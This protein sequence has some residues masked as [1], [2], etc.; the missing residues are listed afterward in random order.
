MPKKDNKAWVAEGTVCSVAKGGGKPAIDGSGFKQFKVGD[1]I[2]VVKAQPS[3][4]SKGAYNYVCSTPGSES[5]YRF[6]FNEMNVGPKRKKRVAG[7][8][9]EAAADEYSREWMR[10]VE[11]WWNSL[12]EGPSITAKENFVKSLAAKKTSIYRVAKAV[13]EILIKSIRGISGPWTLDEKACKVDVEPFSSDEFVGEASWYV[14]PAA[15]TCAYD[16]TLNAG[17]VSVKY[18]FSMLEHEFV[19]IEQGLKRIKNNGP[20]AGVWSKFNAKGW[21]NVFKVPALSMTSYKSNADYYSDKDEVAA[22]AHGLAKSISQGIASMTE[23][24]QNEYTS[25]VSGLVS[26]V[27]KLSSD[28]RFRRKVLGLAADSYNIYLGRDRFIHNE[29]ARKQFKKVLIEKLSRLLLSGNEAKVAVNV[30]DRMVD[31]INIPTTPQTHP[32]FI[33]GPQ[34]PL[35]TLGKEGA[36]K[37]ASEI[38]YHGT[39]AD[40]DSFE[41]TEGWRGVKGLTTELVKSQAVFLSDNMEFSKEWGPRVL[42]CSLRPGLIILDLTGD[43]NLRYRFQDAKTEWVYDESTHENTPVAKGDEALDVLYKI[44]S[45]SKVRGYALHGRYYWELVDNREFIK[46]LRESGFDGMKFEEVAENSSGTTYA[47]L[48]PDNIKIVGIAKT[49]GQALQSMSTSRSNSWLLRKR[50]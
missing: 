16:L 47:I 13:N 3:L 17:D 7:E 31:D 23:E 19:H 32:Q 11:E 46:A 48:D 14:K 44:W 22:Y 34:I 25:S 45:P 39:E 43:N 49:A 1:E 41:I 27:D 10:Q 24:E 9:I 6:S 33:Y 20:D 40:F 26:L 15:S 42:E 36:V 35:R 29:D 30:D 2:T 21:I 38:L 4:L 12:P 18:F 37:R 28:I 8:E 50:K 5:L